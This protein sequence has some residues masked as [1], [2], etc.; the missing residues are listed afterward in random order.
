MIFLFFGSSLAH[1][2]P[3]LQ[4]FKVDGHGDAGNDDLSHHNL[5]NFK[6][7]CGQLGNGPLQIEMD[8]P[9][10]NRYL[11]CDHPHLR[12]ADGLVCCVHGL[13]INYFDLGFLNWRGYHVLLLPLR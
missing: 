11:L 4:L 2:E 8:H 3:K 9:Y 13:D 1:L 7:F 5:P 10:F 6:Q 12:Q